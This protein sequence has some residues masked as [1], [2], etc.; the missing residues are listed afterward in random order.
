MFLV[1]ALTNEPTEWRCLQCGRSIHE[2]ISEFNARTKPERDARMAAIREE[3]N[4]TEASNLDR[5]RGRPPRPLPDKAP[6]P[7]NFEDKFLKIRERRA[8][9]AAVRGADGRFAKKLD[10]SKFHEGR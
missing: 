9:A 10:L 8:N 4:I 6:E 2:P 1:Q 7:S 5:P 3:R